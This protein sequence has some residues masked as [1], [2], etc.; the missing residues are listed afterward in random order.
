MRHRRRAVAGPG[1]RRPLLRGPASA[2]RPGGDGARHADPVPGPSS[3]AF[4]AR[5]EGLS[6]A[7]S[8]AARFRGPRA[9]GR[10]RRATGSSPR[11]VGT[12]WRCWSC[13]GPVPGR[14][15]GGLRRRRLGPVHGPDRGVLPAPVRGPAGRYASVAAARRR[16][17]RSAMRRCCAAGRRLGVPPARRRRRAAGLLEFGRP[18]SLRHPL[19]RSASTGA[20]RR[21]SRDVTAHCG[22]DRPRS[23]IPIAVHGIARRAGGAGR[24][25]RR[26]AG[27]R[28]AGRR[29]TAGSR[30]RGLPRAGD[31]AHLRPLGAP[32]GRS[33]R[34]SAMLYAGAFDAALRWPSPSRAARRRSSAHLADLLRAQIAY[35]DAG[36]AERAAAPRPPSTR[37]PGPPRRPRHL[38]RGPSGRGSRGR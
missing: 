8:C 25:R 11:R 17:S 4:P 26:R 1:S 13:R 10:A 21:R 12:R 15:R 20:H 9:V 34:R 31:R 6:D 23:S 37:Y 2:G 24:G 16:P 27:A 28:G 33:P 18:V 38:S 35:T 29:R 36:S 7:D 19:V 30:P 5:V 3:P 22:P 14:A 32:S